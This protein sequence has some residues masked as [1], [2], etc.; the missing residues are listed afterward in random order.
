MIQLIRY[1]KNYKKESVLAPLFKLLEA[2]FELLVPLVIAGIID[3]GIATGNKNYIWSHGAIL[4]LMGA[5]GLVSAITAQYFS[6]KIAAGF[7]T[8]LRDDL[9]HHIM[10]LSRNETDRIGSATLITR[11][12]NDSNQIQNGVNMFFR[13]VLRS[14]FIVF[15]AMAMAYAIKG[16]AGLLFTAV[17]GLLSVI[18]FFVMKSSVFRYRIVQKKLDG[19]LLK[20][21]ENLEGIRVIRAFRRESAEKKAYGTAAEDLSKEQIIVGRISA[22][23][24]PLTY[25]VINLGLAAILKTGAVQ[26]NAGTL[27]QGQIVALVNYISQIL[28][29]LLK[30]ANLIIMLSKASACAKRINEIF[31]LSNSMQNGTAD[32]TMAPPSVEF[33]NVSFTYPGAGEPSLTNISF[34]AAPGQTIGII[35]GTG[36]GKTTLANLIPRFYD[37]GTGEIR[38]GG[39]NIQHYTIESLRKAVGIVEQTTR[40][41]SG[42]IAENL[43]WGDDTADTELLINSVVT[44]QAE[45]VIS[46]KDGGLNGVVEQLGRNFSGGQKQR[47]SIARTLVRRPR[48]LILD[49][50][51]SALD[52]ATD[53]ALRKAIK[54]ACSGATLFIISQRVTTIRHADKI[55]VLDDGHMAGFDTHEALLKNSQ[56]YHEICMSQL[57]EK[58]VGIV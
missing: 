40:L 15:G 45:A 32:A 57:S 53:A 1:L 27:T 18:V 50:S 2:T 19:L 52:F 20:T 4:L 30:L 47:L 7:G 16:T 9:F 41:F 36:S 14:P 38:I 55:I 5:I 8:E 23:M 43:R 13:L 51:S 56:L 46:A 3:V 6:S 21:S 31:A 33:N 48:I 17:I 34:T 22:F 49:D 54:T 58:E 42:T 39:E 11:M 35:G 37:A 10:G 24:N 29:E 25:A 26:V 12:I 28:I 44:A